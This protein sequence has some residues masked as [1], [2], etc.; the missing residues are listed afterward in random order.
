MFTEIKSS[1]KLPLFVSET[2]QTGYT[3]IYYRGEIKDFITLFVRLKGKDFQY[4]VSS[5]YLQNIL[6][7][8]KSVKMLVIKDLDLNVVEHIKFKNILLSENKS[9]TN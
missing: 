8:L 7:G 2:I 4:Q 5:K 1:N 9:F 3:E 6:E